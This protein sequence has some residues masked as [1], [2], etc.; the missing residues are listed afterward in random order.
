MAQPLR[1]EYPEHPIAGV[2]AV[3][4]DRD[5]VLLVKR[6]HEPGK[7]CWS[8]PGGVVEVGEPVEKAVVREVKE[9]T[10]LDIQVKE[11]LA[12]T[13]VITPDEENRIKFH[14]VLASFLAQV[15]GGSLDDAP[16]R[17]RIRWFAK[18][19]LG[20]VEVAQTALRLLEKVSFLD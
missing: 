15:T 6:T 12:V 4:I 17:S 10:G 13:D 8:I 1:R 20:S 11:L 18:D 7:G 2:G 19:Q 9:E 3:L 14:Y 16:E 5:R